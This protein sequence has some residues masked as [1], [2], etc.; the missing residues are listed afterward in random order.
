M[1]IRKLF[2]T[3]YIQPKLSKLKRLITVFSGSLKVIPERCTTVIG[4]PGSYLS[5]SN[6]SPSIEMDIYTFVVCIVSF[7]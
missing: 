2:F 5:L 1:P 7:Y 6:G 4:A 3:K